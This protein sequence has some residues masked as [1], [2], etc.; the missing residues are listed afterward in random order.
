MVFE[1]VYNKFFREVYS[2]D[3]IKLKLIILKIFFL[4]LKFFIL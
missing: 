2:V 1:K 3:N 4:L